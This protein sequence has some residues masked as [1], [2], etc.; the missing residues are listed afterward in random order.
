MPRKNINEIQ[1]AFDQSMLKK[2]CEMEEIDFARI[3]GF[4]LI[5][6]D[7]KYDDEFYLFQDNGADVLYVAHLDTVVRH[8]DRTARFLETADGLLVNSGALDDRL[9]AYVGLDL[10]PRLG[11]KH[12]ILFTV[13]EESGRSTAQFFDPP[14]EYNWGIEFDRGG[15][16]V[17]MYEY[18]DAET[19]ALVEASGARVDFGSFSDICYLDHLEIKCFNWGVGYDGN[20][21]S[22]KGFAFLE[23]TFQMVDHYLD[24]YAANAEEYLP[25]DGDTDPWWKD[26]RY[27]WGDDTIL[28]ADVVEDINATYGRDSAHGDDEYAALKDEWKRGGDPEWRTWGA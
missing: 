12:D 6:V 15:T 13:G 16:D 21:H 17:V 27:D 9:G 10:L 19:K 7:T 23:D 1:L 2:V 5:Q 26:S 4:E 28:D 8:K 20:Y 25:H 3:P 18:H 11:I 14:K 22:T 24:F